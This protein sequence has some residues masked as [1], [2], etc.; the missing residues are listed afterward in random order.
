LFEKPRGGNMSA[1]QWFQVLLRQN[2]PPKMAKTDPK[3]PLI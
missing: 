1:I 2:W 3:S